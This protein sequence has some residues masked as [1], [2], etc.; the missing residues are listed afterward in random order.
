[1]SAEDRQWQDL[2]QEMLESSGKNAR[3]DDTRNEAGDELDEMLFLA[4]Q[5]QGLG[6]SKMPD[7]EAALARAR[8]RVLQSI[9]APARAPAQPPFWRRWTPPTF[10]WAPTALIAALAIA[11]IFGLALFLA[12]ICLMWA[13]FGAGFFLVGS[14]IVYYASGTFAV[15]GIAALAEIGLFTAAALLMGAVGDRI[16]RRPRHCRRDLRA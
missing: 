8:E 3:G 7:S 5:L 13:V 10:S 16:A 11:L 2:F 4:Q 1:M 14:I 12:M 9:P 15:S 6:R